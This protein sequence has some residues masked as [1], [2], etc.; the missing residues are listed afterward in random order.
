MAQ[1]SVKKI[2]V[3]AL[4]SKMDQFAVSQILLLIKISCSNFY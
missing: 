2:S 1:D 3:V 4:T